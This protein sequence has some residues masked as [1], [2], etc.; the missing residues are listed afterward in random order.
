MQGVLPASTDRAET[1]LAAW[2]GWTVATAKVAVVAVVRNRETCQASVAKSSRWGFFADA[3]KLGRESDVHTARSSETPSDSGQPPRGRGPR[4]ARKGAGG[5]Q[6]FA[7]ELGHMRK[8]FMT[9]R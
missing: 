3:T 5:T 4:A 8:H 2:A 1:G 9:L 6:G 7:E